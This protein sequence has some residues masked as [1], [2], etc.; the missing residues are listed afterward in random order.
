ML[1]F[2]FACFIAFSV[3][4]Y[5]IFEIVALDSLNMCYLV[6]SIFRFLKSID[7]L[8]ELKILLC[9]IITF[10]FRSLVKIILELYRTHQNATLENS[11]DNTSIVV[12]ED[13]A[14][15]WRDC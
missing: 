5:L 3:L 7:S 14:R 4:V 8:E 2:F 15:R 10:L 11:T 6:L 1:L 13:S 9:L 12:V